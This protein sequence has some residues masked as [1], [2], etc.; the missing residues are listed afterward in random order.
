MLNLQKR[1]NKYKFLCNDKYF[2]K[3]GEVEEINSVGIGK[4]I[5]RLISNIVE[6]VNDVYRRNHIVID[7]QFRKNFG[8]NTIKRIKADST[9]YSVAA[10]SILAKVERDRLMKNLHA[11]FPNYGFNTNVGYP[12]QKHIKALELYG[13]T[14]IHRSSFSPIGKM[15]DKIILDI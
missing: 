1:E 8:E 5:E 13:P 7:G 12:T 14:L 4:T 6:E 15:L 11:T 3:F 10:A 9:Y 2:V